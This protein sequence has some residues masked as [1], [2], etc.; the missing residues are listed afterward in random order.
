MHKIKN[1]TAPSSFLDEFE[2]PAHSHP[3][4]FSS[5]NHREPQI[6]LHKC[7]FRISIRGS[8][9]SNSLVGSTGKEIQS[10]SLFK[11]KIKGKLR[12]FENEVTFF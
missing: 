10:F 11:T 12:N 7:R 6:K 2:Q 1:K 4:H 9:K 5:G 8:A 3:T